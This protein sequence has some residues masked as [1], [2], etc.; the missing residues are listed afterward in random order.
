MFVVHPFGHPVAVL[1]KEDA[2]FGVL[3]VPRTQNGFCFWIPVQGELFLLLPVVDR[4]HHHLAE[5]FASDLRPPGRGFL[6]KM[7]GE[8]GF[9]FIKHVRPALGQDRPHI[10]R[11]GQRIVLIPIWQ[12]R[13]DVPDIPA[14]GAEVD[15]EGPVILGPRRRSGEVEPQFPERLLFVFVEHSKPKAVAGHHPPA[16]VQ[17][18][19]LDIGLFGEGVGLRFNQEA[20]L[21]LAILLNQ[22]PLLQVGAL[23]KFAMLKDCKSK[24][25]PFASLAPHIDDRLAD[26][27][28][29][30]SW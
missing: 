21:Q 9:G 28:L 14:S 29:S 23:R 13:V 18:C 11:R 25:P 22:A 19:R 6:A 7:L 2:K 16:D 10:E 5:P 26:A 17:T 3:L 24:P 27:P 12:Q 30:P 4:L 20:E 1:G 8:F 15:I